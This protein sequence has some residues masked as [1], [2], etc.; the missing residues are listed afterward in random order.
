MNSSL[1]EAP[2]PSSSSGSKGNSSESG[3]LNMEEGNDYSRL[4]S[5]EEIDVEDSGK[6]D[7][8]K[9]KLAFSIARIMEPSRPKTIE[10]GEVLRNSTN[11]SFQIPSAFPYLHMHN[12]LAEGQRRAAILEQ[13]RGSFLHPAFYVSPSM[14]QAY[15]YGV[16]NTTVPDQQGVVKKPQDLSVKAASNRSSSPKNSESPQSS[17][18]KSEKSKDEGS[19]D[20]KNSSKTFTC[21][22]CGKIFNA[23]YN[24]TRH[25]PV[26]TGARPFVC[27]IC[28][29]G[30]L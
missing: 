26:H 11:S 6:S 17:P 18:A 24:L 19:E 8:N 20:K 7:L 23:H 9:N 4:S 21:P 16:P 13:T 14:V 15:R 12:L 5:E 29:K 10:P 25:M 3:S 2:S 28:G 30:E 22:E 1:A 27:K